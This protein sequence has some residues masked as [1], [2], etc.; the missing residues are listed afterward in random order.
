[1]DLISELRTAAQRIPTANGRATPEPV[2]SA[3]EI[4]EFER[5]VGRPI[6]PF[7]RRVYSEVGNGGFGPGFGLLGLVTGARND[8]GDSA[9][10]L[11]AVFRESNPEDENWA[12]DGLVPIA[13]WGCAIYS[14]VDLRTE[15]A[16][17]V[18]FDPNGHGPDE[19]WEGAW[20]QEAEASE[21]WLQTWIEGR[22]AFDSPAA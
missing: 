21:E 13:H 17:V 15:A 5:R 20:S 16:A 18:R 14:C 22:L 4:A 12:P 11:L 7:W 3:E 10:E 6:P 2:A 9:A 1:M 19:G 8:E